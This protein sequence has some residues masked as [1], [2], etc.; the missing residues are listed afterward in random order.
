MAMNYSTLTSAIVIA[1]LAWCSTVNQN[2]VQALSPSSSFP[3][4]TSQQRF[5]K[6]RLFSSTEKA[7]Y[8]PKWKKKKTLA[9]EAGS[10]DGLGFEK[11]GLTGRIPVVFEQGN[12][13]KTSLAFA[14]QPLRDVASQA[15]QYIKYQ[16][17]KGECGTCEC[18]VNGKWIRPCVATVPALAD[19]EEF[20]IQLKAIS[21][22]SASS[23]TFF[24]IRS[25]IMGFWN[26][27]LGMVGFVKMRRAAQKNWSD[28][29]SYEGRVAQRTR[30]IRA[31]RLAKYAN[32]SP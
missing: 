18:M 23:G 31:A 10:A 20:K 27:L 1:L 2:A 19:G 26:N 7:G 6:S 15:G 11:V 17:G 32:L 29:Q 21:A 28:R 13:T 24:S 22:K 3:A 4:Q 8:E 5:T 12:N 14:G 16:C 9:E 30:E 25:F